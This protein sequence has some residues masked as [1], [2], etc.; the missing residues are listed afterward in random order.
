MKRKI[1]YAGILVLL[2]LLWGCSAKEEPV[3]ETTAVQTEAVTV[4]TEPAP[5]ETEAEHDIE[6]YELDISEY[7]FTFEKYC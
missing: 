5:V 1:L 3:P 4:P 7:D 6:L 2:L